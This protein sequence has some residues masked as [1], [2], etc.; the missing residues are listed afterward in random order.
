MEHLI[1][2]FFCYVKINKNGQKMS[3]HL[4]WADFPRKYDILQLIVDAV[5]DR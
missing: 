1:Q 2:R 5:N 3:F 4:K